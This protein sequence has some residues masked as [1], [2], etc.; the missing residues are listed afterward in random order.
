[1]R[2]RRDKVVTGSIHD[3]L[4]GRTTVAGIDTTEADPLPANQGVAVATGE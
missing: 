1:M 3:A 4:S 2:G